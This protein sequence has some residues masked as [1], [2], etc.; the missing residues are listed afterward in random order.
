M[1]HPWTVTR[2]TS[3]KTSLLVCTVLICL[4][5]LSRAASG[6]I[7]GVWMKSP[8]PGQNPNKVT[9]DVIAYGPSAVTGWIIYL[10]DQIVY[11]TNVI[12]SEIT[13]QVTMSNGQHL[14]YARAWDAQGD[15][16]TSGTLFI[17]VGTPPPSSTVLPTPP[18]NAQV[19]S[20][21]QNNTADWTTCSDCA[22]GTNT[23]ANYW[24]APFQNTPSRSGSS[25]EMYVD[26][27]QWSNV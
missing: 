15:F 5:T 21:M 4:M 10:D 22:H 19:V 24:M 23:T 18:D 25:L 3:R 14:L 2:M 7:T 1:H 12:T 27:L 13:Q 20:Q 17:Q 8:Q 6:Q 11:Q 9:V 26:G 16:N